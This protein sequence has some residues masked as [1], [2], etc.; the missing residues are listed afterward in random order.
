MID[1]SANIFPN[2]LSNLN[3]N[4]SNNIT[5]KIITIDVLNSN[6]SG[7]MNEYSIENTN[8]DQSEKSLPID[9]DIE[10]TKS[11]CINDLQSIQTDNY[12]DTQ[13]N[14]EIRDNNPFDQSDK[15][16]SGQWI[17]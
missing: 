11:K 6:E 4:N 8:N 10:M 14:I 9:Q 12:S 7:G 2:L 13:M 17:G 5:K 16:Y 1:E 15:K 3:Y